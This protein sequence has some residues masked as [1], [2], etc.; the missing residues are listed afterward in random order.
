MVGRN[1][2]QTSDVFAKN[3]N[4]GSLTS[5]GSEMSSYRKAMH[6]N[7]LTTIQNAE[8]SFEA[9]AETLKKNEREKEQILPNNDERRSF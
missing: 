5:S 7:E 8:N 9:R 6:A 2:L 1:H 4:T 3:R